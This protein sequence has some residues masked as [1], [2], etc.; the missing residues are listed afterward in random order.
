[1]EEN[2]EKLREKLEELREAIYKAINIAKDAKRIAESIGGEVNRVV[3]GQLEHYTI[4]HL[5]TF[6]DDE[7]ECGSVPSLLSFIE[8]EGESCFSQHT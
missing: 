8:E 6:A 2:V 7:D 5:E 4:P 3:A 1:M